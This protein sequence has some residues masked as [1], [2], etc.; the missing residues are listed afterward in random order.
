MSSIT[1]FSTAGIEDGRDAAGEVGA[2]VMQ[3]QR[4]RG[5][6]VVAARET[7]R[8]QRQVHVRVDETGHHR[9]ARDVQLGRAGGD[10]VADGGDPSPPR[11]GCWSGRARR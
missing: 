5:R 4:A 9:G 10:V 1:T 11:C 3:P 2:H 8:G 6:G 7:A